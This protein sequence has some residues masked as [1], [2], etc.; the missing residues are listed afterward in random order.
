MDWVE[1]YRAVQRE[2]KESPHVPTGSTSSTLTLF[3]SFWL[4]LTELL[5]TPLQI[6][7]ATYSTGKTAERNL[8]CCL[9]ACRSFPFSWLS[10]SASHM[11]YLCSATSCFLLKRRHKMFGCSSSH[12]LTCLSSSPPASSL[13]TRSMHTRPYK[14]TATTRSFEEL[15]LFHPRL[16]HVQWTEKK[17]TFITT[18]LASMGGGCVC[19]LLPSTGNNLD[20]SKRP[21]IKG[22]LFF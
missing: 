19:E 7:T 2:G 20:A 5:L 12:H 15:S 14:H 17:P 6:G 1:H 21:G 13:H 10:G 4:L 16:N 18:G 22:L 11:I 9:L 3:R 8:P